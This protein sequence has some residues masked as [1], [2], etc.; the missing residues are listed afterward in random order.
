MTI[1][2]LLLQARHA[3]DAARLEERRSFATMA[4]VDEAQIIPFDLLTGTPTLAEVRRYDALMVG[5]SGA[6]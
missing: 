4:G 3:D 2:I 5:G 6:Y 1:N